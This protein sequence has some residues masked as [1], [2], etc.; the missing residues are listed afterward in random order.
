MIK[1]MVEIDIN[2]NDIDNKNDHP[3]NIID[4]KDSVNNGENS[5]SIA[6]VLQLDEK[7]DEKIR[8]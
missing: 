5:T 4:D 1:T 7:V 2:I 3:N 6:I 8:G